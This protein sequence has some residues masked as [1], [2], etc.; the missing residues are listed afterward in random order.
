MRIRLRQ[1][2]L[3]AVDLAGTE[4]AVV[5]TL[6]VSLCYRDPGVGVFGLRNA[7]FPIGEQLLEIVSPIQDGTTA[8]RLIDKRG[9]DT[10]YMVILEVD[11]L[12]TMRSRI[13]A[14]GA[15][16]VYEAVTEGI[17]GLHLHPA[18]VGGAILSIDRAETWGE[19]PW[20]GPEW[21]AH[22]IT[23]VVRAVVAVEI[24]ANDPSAMAA[25]WSEVLG[26]PFAGDTIVLDEG[27]VRF[28][29]AGDRGEGV[30]AYEFE[31]AAGADGFDVVIAGTRLYTS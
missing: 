24:E 31:V 15:R 10:G 13:A 12:D 28:V 27:E 25:R 19:W 26:R 1:V 5:D 7:L 22:V 6:G 11:D 9:G 14:A 21:R 29:P 3:A 23:D 18:D 20:A 30:S 4:A 17:V 2:V 8:G 16:I